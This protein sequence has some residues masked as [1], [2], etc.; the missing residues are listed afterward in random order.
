MITVVLNKKT[1]VVT[2]EVIILLV[3][4]VRSNWNLLSSELNRWEQLSWGNNL[5]AHSTEQY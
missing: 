3:A 2:T 1:S 4:L 5:L